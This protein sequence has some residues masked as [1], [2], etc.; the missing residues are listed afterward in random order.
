MVQ[1]IFI[2]KYDKNPFHH[3]TLLANHDFQNM[4]RLINLLPYI[5]KS[6]HGLRHVL[7][8]L[9]TH[10][11][12]DLSFVYLLHVYIF[13]LFLEM[14]IIYTLL[15]FKL[16]LLFS[17]VKSGSKA[18]YLRLDQLIPKQSLF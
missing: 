10:I 15:Y 12:I 14:G 3:V 18:A 5:A 13:H 9:W 11:I 2:Y 16:S 4:I 1:P 8:T 6:R 7:C 17:R